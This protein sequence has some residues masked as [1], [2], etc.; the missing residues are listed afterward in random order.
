MK[1]LDS[2]K[3]TNQFLKNC[4]RSQGV[5]DKMFSDLIETL[6]TEIN[7]QEKSSLNKIHNE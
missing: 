1:F 2:H 5:S 7:I 6:S 3:I 4:L